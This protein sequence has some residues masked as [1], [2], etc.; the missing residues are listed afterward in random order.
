MGFF[1]YQVGTS[2]RVKLKRCLCARRDL[3][4]AHA[5][6]LIKSLSNLTHF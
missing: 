4:A 6:L 1:C 3:M 2:N 5:S